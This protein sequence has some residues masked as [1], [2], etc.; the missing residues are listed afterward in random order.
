M[1]RLFRRA[2]I[3]KRPA[4]RINPAVEGSGTLANEVPDPAPME[5]APKLA[6]RTP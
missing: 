6:F 4:T 5:A 3:I 1:R 2:A